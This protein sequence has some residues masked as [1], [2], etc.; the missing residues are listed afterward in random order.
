MKIER[1]TNE[2]LEFV[3]F[4]VEVGIYLVVFHD[5]PHTTNVSAD[6]KAMCERRARGELIVVD[7]DLMMLDEPNI[8]YWIR[9]F[10]RATGMVLCCCCWIE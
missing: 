7:D 3:W 6:S 4:G 10:I 5:F 2:E 8:P 9:R 1:G